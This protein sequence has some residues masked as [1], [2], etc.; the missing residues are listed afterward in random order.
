VIRA[1]ATAI[2]AEV[3][4]ALARPSARTADLRSGDDGTGDSL[5]RALA[6]RPA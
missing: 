4:P 3:G 6:R 5:W 2:S 1:T